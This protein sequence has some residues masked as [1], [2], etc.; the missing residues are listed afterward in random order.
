MWLLQPHGANVKNGK[1]ISCRNMFV[2]IAPPIKCYIVIILPVISPVFIL[3]RVF[4]V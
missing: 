1:H 2:C 4:R 3:L